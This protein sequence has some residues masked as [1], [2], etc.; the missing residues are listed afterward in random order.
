MSR[1]TETAKIIL[2]DLS[3]IQ[4]EKQITETNQIICGGSS[5]SLEENNTKEITIQV[6]ESNCN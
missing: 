3:P 6:T 4:V 2:G 1:P 5:V